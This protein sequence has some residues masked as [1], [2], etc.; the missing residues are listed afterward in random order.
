MAILYVD[1]FII[2]RIGLRHKIYNESTGTILWQVKLRL[3]QA[4]A[5]SMHGYHRRQALI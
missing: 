2:S 5:G 1:L 4:A 3:L